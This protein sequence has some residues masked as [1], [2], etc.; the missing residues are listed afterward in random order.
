M[1]EKQMYETLSYSRKEFQKIFAQ[2]Y[3]KGP[4]H[5]QAFFSTIYR[6]GH[7]N[8]VNSPAFV[9]VPHLANQLQTRF[10]LILAKPK[11]I[12]EDE[13]HIKFSLY[14]ADGL[15]AETVI[16]KMK[17]YHTLCLSSQAGCR[18]GCTFCQTGKL[19]L[20]GQ[21][22]CAQIMMQI[23]TAKFHFGI[24]IK[25]IVFMGMGESLDNF[26]EVLQSI[27]IMTDPYGLGIGAANI[28]IST[29]GSLENLTKFEQ[30]THW[31]LPKGEKGPDGSFSPPYRN[32]KLAVSLNATNDATR[33]QIMPINRVY[34]MQV[35]KKA[36]KDIPI[37]RK[38]HD[39]FIEYVLIPGVNDSCKN[40]QEL[41]SYLKDLPCVVNL[42]PYHPHP[43][44]H[45]RSPTDQELQDFLLALVQSGQVCR[46]RH[47]KGEKMAAA[48]GQLGLTSSPTNS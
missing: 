42:I 47:S 30:L 4:Y 10:P 35:L 34:P 39:L 22:S 2:D 43:G 8:I 28:T 33:D 32:I 31:K 45:W 12:L 46:M 25:N 24:N 15:F 18:W 14:F 29:V 6:Q 5:S 21:L 20:Q 26:E 48:C 38:Y 11:N 36:L 41:I 40:V 16:L 27:H 3:D 44:S 13:G 23:L 19:G 1:S 17:T 7:T 37:R 9:P